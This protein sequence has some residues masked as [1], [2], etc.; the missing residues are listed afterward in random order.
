MADKFNGTP[1]SFEEQIAR[2]SQD[3]AEA[4]AREPIPY[5]AER[6]CAMLGGCGCAQR[7]HAAAAAGKMAPSRQQCAYWVP[8]AFFDEK[9]R[10]ML[11]LKK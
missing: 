4:A 3:I 7:E 2:K 1:P 8:L 6:K 5:D 9:K 11:H 10:E